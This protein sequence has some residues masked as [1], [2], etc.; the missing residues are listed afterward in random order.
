MN[1][2]YIAPVTPYDYIQYAN[3]TV[4]ATR[5]EREIQAVS[6][7]PTVKLHLDEASGWESYVKGQWPHWPE[8]SRRFKQLNQAYKK[9]GKSKATEE[10]KAKITGKGLNINEVI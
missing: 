7:I 3:R 4:E 10:A 9:Q 6:L 5:K 1:M 8:K 2:G